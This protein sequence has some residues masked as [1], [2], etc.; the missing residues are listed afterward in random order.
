M[1][2]LTS[3]TARVEIALKGAEL[4]S[5][6][7]LASGLE[8]MWQADPAQWGRHAPLLFPIV[9]KV[10]NDSYLYEGEEYKLPQHGFA[11]DQEFQL[12]LQDAH[13]LTFQLMAS[14]ASKEIY[15]FE[16]ELRV[17]YELR[18][19]VL[20][21]GWHVRNPAAAPHELLFSIG[22]HPAFNCPLRP[23]A[24]E[25]FADYSFHFD[26]PVTLHRQL[27]H[28]GLRSG[29]TAPVLA[30]QHS[31][32]L[33][34]ELFADDALVFDH[35][36]FTRITLQ[37]ADKTGPFVRMQFDGFPYL[38]L[39]T[40]GPGAAFVCIEPWQGVASPVGESQE[41]R[42]KEGILTLAPSQE[43]EASYSIEIG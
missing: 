16:F 37:K 17:R 5:F 1:P 31:L 10:P 7:G 12:I 15:P 19:S 39:W 18:G 36:D 32:P 25:Q 21:V 8:Y 34:Y 33:T 28:G 23:A 43:F 9:G 29:E 26:H 30:A 13:S 6:I 22:A 24:G 20:T 2:T 40:K 4:T 42:D 14:A 27:L 38:G 11:R 3:A 35:F 41:L